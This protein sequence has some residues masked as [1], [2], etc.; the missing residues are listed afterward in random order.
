VLTELW[1]QTNE[2]VSLAVLEGTTIRFVGCVEST[3]SV[4]VG[5]RTG[6]VRAAHGSARHPEVR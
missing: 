6:V 4:R 2:T 5:N 1:E 3:P